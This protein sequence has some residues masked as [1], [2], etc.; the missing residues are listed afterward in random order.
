MFAFRRSW[1]YLRVL[2]EKKTIN[3]EHVSCASSVKPETELIVAVKKKNAV[4]EL[5]SRDYKT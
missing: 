2:R 4:V 1:L 3:Y 5:N